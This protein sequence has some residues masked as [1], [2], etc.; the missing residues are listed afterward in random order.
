MDLLREL[1][2]FAPMASSPAAS[3][4]SG[5]VIALEVAVLAASGESCHQDGA[6]RH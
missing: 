2:A 3:S 1:R 6:L 4:G 5:E